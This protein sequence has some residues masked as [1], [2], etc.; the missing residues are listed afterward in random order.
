MSTPWLNPNSCVC[1]WLTRR[2]SQTG[3]AGLYI[4]VISRRFWS[5]YVK[6][7]TAAGREEWR[8]DDGWLNPR[9]GSWNGTKSHLLKT[10]S[11]SFFTPS[12]YPTRTHTH[13]TLSNAG[14]PSLLS[15]RGIFNQGYLCS[16]CG[17]GAHKE[18]L[19]RFGGCGKTGENHLKT[20]RRKEACNNMMQAKKRSMVSFMCIPESALKSF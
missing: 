17:V 3:A 6:E 18:C 11:S 7:N 20:H 10:S 12:L 16:K 13:T 15:S 1:A 4:I 2:V 5:S 19:G 14:C 8:G 9:Q